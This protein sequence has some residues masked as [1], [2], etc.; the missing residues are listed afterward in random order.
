MDGGG[1]HRGQ[2][3]FSFQGTGVFPFFEA[4]PFMLQH[5]QR[6]ARIPVQNTQCPAV[7]SASKHSK[8]IDS[9]SSMTIIRDGIRLY[10]FCTLRSSRNFHWPIRISAHID[11]VVH[12]GS[13]PSTYILRDHCLID[14]WV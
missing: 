1:C 12:P 8:R 9:L 3:T 7:S 13:V 14:R 11:G 10:P 6:F 2:E 5:R 4:G